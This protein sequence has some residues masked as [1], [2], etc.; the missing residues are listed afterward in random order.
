[1][2]F[3]LLAPFGAAGTYEISRRL[4]TDEPLSWSAV[5][6]AVWG[7]AGKE[8]GW[9]ALVSLFTFIIWIDLAVFLFLLF[10]G[11]RSRR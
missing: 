10:C 11:L 6:G 8:L 1:M 5:L 3:A 4:E 7:R 9:L 2:G